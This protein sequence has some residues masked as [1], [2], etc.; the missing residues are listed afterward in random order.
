MAS[1]KDVST[2]RTRLL[3]AEHLIG[4]APTC[5]LW[6]NQRYVSARHATVYFSGDRW[7]LRDLGSRNGTFL[8]GVRL[9]PGDECALRQGS[10]ISFGRLEQQWELVDET[11]PWAMA[12]PL[13]GGEPAQLEGELLALP[14]SEDPRATIYRNADGAWV[15]E[16]PES[17]VQIT[18]LQT[19][20]VDGRAFRFS[21]PQGI[22]KTSLADPS[23]EPEVRHLALLFSVSRDEEHVEVHATCGAHAFNLG[24]HTYNYLLLTLARRRLTD[25]A[26]G[27]AE[28]TCGWIYQE[29]LAHD[30]SMAPPQLNI[31]VFRIRK[32]FATLGVIDA[33]NVIERRPR[34]RQLRIGVGRLSVVML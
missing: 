10:K 8:D 4:R 26:E 30:P 16:Q 28:T 25:A 23:P 31:D 13:D 17:V 11:P 19:F 12:V 15:L 9:R 20:E 22:S 27:L 1:L 5:A 33:A 6:L 34:T 14:S 3:E 24:A 21:C 32:H 18:N 29:D 7:E 2:G